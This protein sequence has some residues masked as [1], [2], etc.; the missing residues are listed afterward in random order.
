MPEFIR[1]GKEGARW[2]QYPRGVVEERKCSLMEQNVSQIPGVFASS[3]KGAALS[4][5]FGPN[6]TALPSDLALVIDR[7][8]MLKAALRAQIVSL[9]EGE[10]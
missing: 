3:E 8:P 7:W 2:P 10:A 4:G 6:P 1:L 5:A 9:V